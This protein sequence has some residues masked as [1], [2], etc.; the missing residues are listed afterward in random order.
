[1]N[2][3]VRISEFFETFMPVFSSNALIDLQ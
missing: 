1:V 2:A 3:A